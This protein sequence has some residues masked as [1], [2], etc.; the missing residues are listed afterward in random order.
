MKFDDLRD[1]DVTA[2]RRDARVVMASPAELPV[3]RIYPDPENI[4]R[5]CPASTI[6]ELAETIRE[7]GLLQAITVRPHPTEPEAY[8][9]SYGE[10]RWR[11]FR[12]LGR[13]M[14]PAV[15]DET[16]DPYRQAI[17]NLQREDLSP[18]HVAQFVAT[19]EAAGDSRGMIAKRLGKSR[20]FI[21][22]LAHLMTAPLEIRQAFEGARIDTRTA[23]L[24][25]RHYREHPE[26][27][28]QWLQ[29]AA[30][31]GRGR[32]S[33]ELGSVRGKSRPRKPV[34][35]GRSKRYNALAVTVGGRDATLLLKPGS[36]SDQA[37]VRY[38][39][40]TESPTALRDMTLSRWVR[41]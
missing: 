19:R 40:G 5:H 6:A 1:F 29:D 34:L 24:L 8:L 17:E 12:L 23:Y 28:T 30:P 33:R 9:I 3:D 11:A 10:R 32:V 13:T 36:A 39:D 22:E 35:S 4:R 41:L 16:F 20:S 37:M 26:R 27:I 14:I 7:D 15:V 21:C 2:L 31:I 25:A 18:F 38:A